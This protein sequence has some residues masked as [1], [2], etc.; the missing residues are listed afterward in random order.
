MNSQKKIVR[1]TLI[2]LLAYALLVATHKG[3]YWPFS[4]YPM[5]SKAGNPWTR[6]LVR[7]VTNIDDDFLWKI[8]DLENLNGSPVPMR[9]IGVDQI[10]YSNFVSKTQQW[11][12]ERINALRTM[13]GEK[14]L[15]TN[16]WMIYKVHGKL[17]GDD[18]VVVNTVPYLLFKADTTVFNPNLNKSDYFRK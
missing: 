15:S 9:K 2:S 10:D 5:F 4:I 16:D 18:S 17:I 14:Y 12:K 13:L 8:S 11:D 3:E 6:A 1:I 7:D